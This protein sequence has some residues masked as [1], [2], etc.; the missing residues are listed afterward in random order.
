LQHGD[1]LKSIYLKK[2]LMC[3]RKLFGGGS[4][5]P[6][7]ITS[8]YVYLGFGINDY[9]GSG[10]DLRGCINDINNEC[11]KLKKE[12]PEFQCLKYFDSKVT[13]QFFLSEIRR[14]IQALTRIYEE[15]G[16]IGML[17]IKYSGHGT[18]IPSA[19][20][21]NGYNEALFLIDGP[22]QDDYIYQ[23]QQES[24]FWLPVL[25]KFDSCFSGDIG[26]RKINGYRKN[27]FMPLPGTTVRHAPVNHLGK[28]DAGQKWIILS[29]CGEEQTSADAFISGTYQG[30]FT[31]SDL[32]SYGRGSLFTR[33]IDRSKE[34]LRISRYE[35]IPELSGPYQNKTMPI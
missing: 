20:E 11:A 29:G 27:R 19:S 28:T 3:F 14:V 26:S 25:A 22:L 7:E 6:A 32:Q 34:I 18:Q 31:W 4:N 35:Q 5:N 23:L 15:T 8:P 17:Y 2:E 10:N 21:P 13:I 12:F 24:P 33:E 1:Y 9:N 16:K 30:A